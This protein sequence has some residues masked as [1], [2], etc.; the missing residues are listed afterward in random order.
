MRAIER[1]TH[2]LETLDYNLR[3]D[4]IACVKYAGPFG[5]LSKDSWSTLVKTITDLFGPS[6]ICGGSKG[7]SNPLD[8]SLYRNTIENSMG[9]TFFPRTS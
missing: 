6:L 1:E 2:R 8:I 5:P 4:I 3:H 9:S 7:L